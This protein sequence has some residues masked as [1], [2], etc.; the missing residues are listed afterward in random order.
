MRHICQLHPLRTIAV[1]LLISYVTENITDRQISKIRKLK[2][3]NFVINPLMYNVLI[4][5]IFNKSL[6]FVNVVET[7]RFFDKKKSQVP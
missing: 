4:L 6:Y 2:V 1:F 3:S 7:E 5:M